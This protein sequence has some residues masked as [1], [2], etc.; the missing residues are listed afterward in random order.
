MGKWWTNYPINATSAMDLYNAL[1]NASLGEHVVF[2][3]SI[4]AGRI[5]GTSAYELKLTA[6]RQWAAQHLK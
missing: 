6:V 5:P 2:K 1:H 4:F 3:P